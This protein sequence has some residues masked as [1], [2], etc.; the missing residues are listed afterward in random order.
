M[1]V[2]GDSEQSEQRLLSREA[3]GSSV[4]PPRRVPRSVRLFGAL[5]VFLLACLVPVLAAGAEPPADLPE[6]GDSS[7]VEEMPRA[8]EQ[9]EG[10][11]EAAA[12]AAQE[13]LASPQGEAERDFSES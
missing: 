8:L 2:S 5:G 10:E 7:V 12:E 4:L 3:K 1:R 13:E 6:S 11:Q 9:A